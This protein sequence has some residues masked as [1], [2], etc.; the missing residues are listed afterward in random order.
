M[1]GHQ[2]LVV[3]ESIGWTEHALQ[4]QLLGGW[5]TV[6]ETRDE[7][8]CIK[9]WVENDYKPVQRFAMSL[10]AESSDLY[11]WNYADGNRTFPEYEEWATSHPQDGDC[12][13]MMIGS[14]VDHQG[15]W[16]DGD[17]SGD[18]VWAICE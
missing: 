12:V 6:L 17:C 4:C 13:S 2:Y 14:G 11:Q 8:F 9:H 16:M 7:W 5:L 3:P 1:E 10:R 18:P 15:Q